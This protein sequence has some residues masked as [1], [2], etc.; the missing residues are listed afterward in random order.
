M[1]RVASAV[2]VLWGAVTVTFLALHL[3]PGS[4]VD[5]IIGQSRVTPEIRAQIIQ[6]YSLDK[7][8]WQ[9]YLGYLGRLLHGDLGHSYNQGVAVSTALEQ[10]AGSTFALLLGGVAFALVGSVVVAVATANR[11]R[12]IR[13]PAATAEVVSVAVP[14]FW[15][16]ILLLTVFS[17]RLHW[18]PAIGANGFN[19]L[20]LPSIALGLAPAAMLSQVLRQGLERVL[21]EP[22][23]IT[24]R[25][26]GLRS[27]AVLLRHALRH[28]VLPV[29]TLTGW[30]VGAF[31]SGAVVIESVFS[32]QGLGHLTVGAISQRDFP[33]V[34]AI[35]LISALVYV[36][37][38]LAVDALYP[39]LD[40][41]LRKA[42]EVVR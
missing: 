16:G 30:L 37:V 6:D 12:W 9:Q 8:L 21:E 32:R 24:A 2:L 19:G 39:L 33:L 20:V 5:A 15:L 25:A 27:A 38:N 4:I 28:A 11:P 3:I 18:F 40:P 17:F 29:V 31:V 26:R 1:R 22:F 14:S 13:G 36:V 34:A 41:R 10:Q 42:P 23:I 7:P 35:V